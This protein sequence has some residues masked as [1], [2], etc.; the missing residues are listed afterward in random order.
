LV[1]I[2]SKSNL[3]ELSILIED[4]DLSI[5]LPLKSYI[6]FHKIFTLEQNLIISK[7]SKAK[8]KFFKKVVSKITSIMEM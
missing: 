2:T 8:P 6:R 1:Q 4:K 7:L 5:D 3:D